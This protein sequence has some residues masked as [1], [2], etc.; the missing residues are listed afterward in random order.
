MGPVGMEEKLR[1]DAVDARGV[2]QELDQ[3]VEQA[4]LDIGRGRCAVASGNDEG[5]ANHC[6]VFFVDAENVAGDAAV[7]HS[8]VAGKDPR[9][10]ILQQQVGGGAVVPSQPLVPKADFALKH[11]A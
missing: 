9:I 5:V 4:K 6:F 8:N 10:Q 7:F 11:G 3:V 2:D 1:L